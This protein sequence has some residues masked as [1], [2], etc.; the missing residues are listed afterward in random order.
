MKLLLA[1]R[2]NVNIHDGFGGTALSDAQDEGHAEIATLIV[3]SMRDSRLLGKKVVI[4]GLVT[5]PE[6]NGRTG[7]VMKFDDEKGRYWIELDETSETFMI[8]SCNLVPHEGDGSQAERA[9]GSMLRT[10]FLAAAFHGD[11]ATIRTLLSTPGAQFLINYQD[12]D[13]AT[14]VSRHSTSRPKMASP[15]S[16]PK[17]ACGS[18]EAAHCCSL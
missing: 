3:N 12:A 16:G 14:M 7:R 18:H 11:T 9:G 13:G 2:C 15:R 5:K 1:A 6:L 8:K 10:Q 17:W 4:K